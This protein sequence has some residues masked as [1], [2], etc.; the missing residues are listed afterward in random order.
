MTN[1][2][3]VEKLTKNEW[4]LYYGDRAERA[5]YLL[6]CLLGVVEDISKGSITYNVMVVEAKEHLEFWA[7][8]AREEQS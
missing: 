2:I 7:S 1:R 6:A 5:E 4:L 3:I 8:G